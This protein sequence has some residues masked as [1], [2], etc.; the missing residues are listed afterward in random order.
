MKKM[1]KLL[2]MGIV[3]TMIFGLTACGGAKDA[4]SARMRHKV[5]R[6]IRQIRRNLTYEGT[7]DGLQGWRSHL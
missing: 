3:C 1:K 5:R 2:A 7:F 6:P 4:S